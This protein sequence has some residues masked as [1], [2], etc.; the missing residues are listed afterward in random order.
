MVVM[1]LYSGGVDKLKKKKTILQSF[2]FVE[3]I[4]ILRI[5]ISKY[6]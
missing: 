1:M 6:L 4:V 3:F 5:H 2:E